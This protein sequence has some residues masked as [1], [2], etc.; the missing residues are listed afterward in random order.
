MNILKDVCR[1]CIYK[2]VR[3]AAIMNFSSATQASKIWGVVRDPQIPFRISSYYQHLWTW[4]QT[5]LREFEF[6]FLPETL[7][8]STRIL[9]NRKQSNVI[10]Q[11]TRE[12]W[13]EYGYSTR[14]LHVLHRTTVSFVSRRLFTRLSPSSW[15]SRWRPT[16]RT[17]LGILC[18]LSLSSKVPRRPTAVASRGSVPTSLWAQVGFRSAGQMVSLTWS[19]RKRPLPTHWWALKSCW[20]SVSRGYNCINSSTVR[21]ERSSEISYWVVGH[22]RFS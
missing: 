9:F 13:P 6:V 12:C 5:Y 11:L 15:R 8:T 16:R 22:L 17:P 19:R 10:L 2:D 20:T 18:L 7:R 3:H 4:I 14:E 21:S 1:Y